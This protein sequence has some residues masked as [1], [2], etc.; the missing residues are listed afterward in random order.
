[1]NEIVY[2]LQKAL[3]I[4]EDYELVVFFYILFP[5]ISQMN[6]S[7]YIRNMIIKHMKTCQNDTL[8]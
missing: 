2:H 8:K 4:V 5:Y 6:A 7:F 3:N 1:M